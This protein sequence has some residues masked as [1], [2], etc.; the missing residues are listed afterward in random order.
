VKLGGTISAA[1]KTKG[2]TGGTIVVTGENIVVRRRQD[3]RSGDAGGGKVM[4]GGDWPRQP[5]KTS[6]QR[7]AQLEAIRSA[8]S[9]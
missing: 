4:L 9:T 6:S 1:G 8:A 5:T 7:E 3:R 2:T